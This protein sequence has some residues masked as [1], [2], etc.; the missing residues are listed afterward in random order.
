MFNRP[1]DADQT[2]PG[3]AAISRGNIQIVHGLGHGG[4]VQ[5]APGTD[6][7]MQGQQ[8]PGQHVP[9]IDRTITGRS[10]AIPGTRD[11]WPSLA[12]TFRFNFIFFQV[13]AALP[14]VYLRIIEGELHRL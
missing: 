7:V 5:F 3:Q 11:I 2:A 1:V 12:G 14:A 6:P 10:C 4:R 8:L 13:L 9:A